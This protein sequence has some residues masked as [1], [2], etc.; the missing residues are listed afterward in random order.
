MRNSRAQNSGRLHSGKPR[1]VY[2]LD[3]HL[4]SAP[5]ASQFVKPSIFPLLASPLQNQFSVDGI[6]SFH[7]STEHLD[8]V[9]LCKSK[10]KSK[11]TAATAAA[12]PS[13]SCGCG[14]N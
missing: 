3:S 2:K 12:I 10:R 5:A 11:L 8:F 6:R 14:R 1:W 4:H 13:C 7:M 9:A